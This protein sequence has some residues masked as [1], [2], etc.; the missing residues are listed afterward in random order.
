MRKGSVRAGV[1]VTLLAA[2]AYASHGLLAKLVLDAGLAFSLLLVVRYVGASGL[3][4]AAT[5][6]KP[7]WRR[8]GWDPDSRAATLAGATVHAVAVITFTAAV[9][10]VGAGI[11]T[12]LL[13]AFPAMVAVAMALTGRERLHPIRIA[14]VLSALVGVGLI[15]AGGAASGDPLGIAL[16]LISAL[17]NALVVLAGDRYLPR[18][19]PI[20]FTSRLCI[21]ATFTFVIVA[22][23]ASS[24][25]S[26]WPSSAW[27]LIPGLI[28]LPTVIGMT[29]FMAGVDRLGPAMASILL[30]TEPAFALILATLILSEPAE[31]DVARCLIARLSDQGATAEA[32][33]YAEAGMA[34]RVRWGSRSTPGGYAH[35]CVTPTRSAP[36]PRA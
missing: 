33:S 17:A 13:Y 5:A 21:G 18:L 4:M 20:G 22:L 19:G 28:V 27:Y 23:F 34:L 30:A 24:W 15:S 14:A 32:I 35:S 1:A 12:V 7:A 25:T 10:R 26:P 6:A 3:L 2:L 36:R 9:L 31:A 16:G 8:P 29:G 11:A